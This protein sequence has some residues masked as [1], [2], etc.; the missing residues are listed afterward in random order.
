MLLVRMELFMV[1]KI[2]SLD[3]SG[4]ERTILRP[5]NV[6]LYLPRIMNYD[7]GAVGGMIGRGNRSTRRK[8]APVQLFPSQIPHDPTRARIWSAAVET[9]LLTA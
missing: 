6:L 8:P 9:L 2:F 3:W 4:T 7:Y 5:L 1:L